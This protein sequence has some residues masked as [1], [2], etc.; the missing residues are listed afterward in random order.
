MKNDHVS[1]G[2]GVGKWAQI[3]LMN[4]E[5]CKILVGNLAILIKVSIVSIFKTAVLQLRVILQEDSHQIYT[6]QCATERLQE[7]RTINKLNIYSPIIVRL[8]KPQSTVQL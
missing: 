2:K 7:Q 5:Q 4:T 3:L 1:I 8:K 6:L